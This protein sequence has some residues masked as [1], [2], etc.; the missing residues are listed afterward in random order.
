MELPSLF[1]KLAIAVGLGLLVG[2]EREHHATKLG[3]IRT[4]PMVTVLG[5]LSALLAQSYG[6]WIIA[7]GL[8]ALSTLIIMGNLA[9]VRNGSWHQGLT[10]E[11][12]M[13]LMFGVGAYL[14]VGSRE[15]AIAVGSGVA[16]LLHFKGPLHGIVQ[17]LG[18]NDLKAMMQFALISFIVL[19]ILP[20]RTFGPYA[21]FNPRST[22]LMVVLIVGISLT[23]YIS[24]K[25]FGARAGLV[26]GGILGGLISSTATSVSYARR[27]ATNPTLSGVGAMV[28]G[29]ASTILYL[30]ILVEIA[31]V[32]PRFL[33]TAG[34]PVLTLGLLLAISSLVL[35]SRSRL[36]QDV[37]LPS[38]ENP[39]EIRSAL[40]FGLIY[41][42]VLF[43]VAAVKQSFDGRGLFVVALLSG[44]TDVDAITL[45]VSQLVNSERLS[46][47]EGWRLI[48][49]ASL[50][51]LAFKGAI[52]AVLGDRSL[53]R[54]L[55]PAF[56]LVLVGGI[57]ILF[58]WP[59]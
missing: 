47:S 59:G 12:A 9:E 23:G 19:P 25:I 39:S 35:W 21:V 56:S 15:V 34:P 7:A 20:D 32:A 28:I 5:S 44:L 50:S 54:R 1:F 3:G 38:Q 37:T 31:A 8:L 51:N 53:V 10:T 6:G 26:L 29:T 41:A 46:G 2:I 49:A 42:V 27:T 58:L 48:V 24:Y 45:S 22:W 4:F 16:I 14:I 33:A 17:K 52:V 57:A 11:V 30:R 55:F 43:T 40:V 18:E 36:E 13:L